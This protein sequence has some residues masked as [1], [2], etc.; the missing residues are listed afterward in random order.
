MAQTQGWKTSARQA[1]D[2]QWGRRL[3]T[4]LHPR[5]L[6]HSP[7]SASKTEAE[8][9]QSRGLRTWDQEK[10]LGLWEKSGDRAGSP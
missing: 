7:R 2:S 3:H 9:G 4:R 10:V 5:A 1:L 8:K 6:G